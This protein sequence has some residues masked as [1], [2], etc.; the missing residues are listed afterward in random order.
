MMRCTHWRRLPLDLARK[1][2]EQS[3]SGHVDSAVRC[4]LSAHETGAH[5]GLLD[6]LEYDTA[7]WLRWC[8]TDVALATLPDCPALGPGPDREGCCLFLDHAEHHTWADTEEEVSR[9]S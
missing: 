6:D 3:S 9:S 5:H 1:A 8:G 4:Q 2:R 7:L